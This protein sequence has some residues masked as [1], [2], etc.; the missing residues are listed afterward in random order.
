MGFWGDLAKAAFD[1]Y[2]ET[3]DK[4]DTLKSLVFVAGYKEDLT[5]EDKKLIVQVMR[6][7][8]EDFSLFRDEAEIDQV[9]NL[10]KDIDINDFFE[11]ILSLRIDRDKIIFFFILDLLLLINLADQDTCTPQNRYNLYLVKKHFDFSRNELARC[12]QQLSDLQNA[13]IDD[14]AEAVESLIGEEAIADLVRDNPYLIGERTAEELADYITLC[15]LKSISF[16]TAYNI[17]ASD[18]YKDNIFEIIIDMDEK[19]SDD[20]YIKMLIQLMDNVTDIELN[21]FFGNDLSLDFDIR[22]VVLLFTLLVVLMAR[23][24]EQS[25]ATPQHFF[26]FYLLKQHFDFSQENME[27]CY[28]LAKE[29]YSISTEITKKLVEVDTSDEAIKKLLEEHTEI[30]S[31]LKLQTIK[32]DQVQVIENTSQALVNNNTSNKNDIEEKLIKLKSLFDKGILSNEEFQTEKQKIL[33]E[34]TQGPDIQSNAEQII[35]IIDRYLSAIAKYNTN[36]NSGATQ[37]P[38]FAKVFQNVCA[39]IVPGVSI[40][41]IYGYIDSTVFSKGKAG[42]VFTNDSLYIREPGDNVRLEYSLIHGMYIKN[43]NLY[44]EGVNLN[45]MGLSYNTN[46]LKTCLEEIIAV[47]N[48]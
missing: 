9:Y 35:A 8:D 41:D 3:T 5:R 22:I 23:L 11:N 40:K 29:T 43:N 10:L 19:F 48:N 7:V 32:Q 17:T 37:N 1:S 21:S 27:V 12:Y 6:C 13:D 15:M 26:N 16:L 47:V 14:T 30:Q 36:Y 20:Q 4:A 34:Y 45:I 24:V 25:N 33:L 2:V 46:T 28:Q 42:L 31:Q 38:E 44:F 39:Y 18:E